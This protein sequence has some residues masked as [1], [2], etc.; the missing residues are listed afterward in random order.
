MP[1]C[2]GKNK[3]GTPC[4]RVLKNEGYCKSHRPADGSGSSAPN[5]ARSAAAGK[6]PTPPIPSKSLVT[7]A[8]PGGL[9]GRP[10]LVPAPPSRCGPVLPAARGL[11]PILSA[12]IGLA[13]V[14]STPPSVPVSFVVD[15]ETFVYP[16]DLDNLATALSHC[17][18]QLITHPVELKHMFAKLEFPEIVPTAVP[19]TWDTVVIPN[20]VVV[21]KSELPV[22]LG[23]GFP[24]EVLRNSAV[25][26]RGTTLRTLT[27]LYASCSGGPGS[28]F[29]LRID[30]DEGERMEITVVNSD[31]E[32]NPEAN[33][34]AETLAGEELIDDTEV[35]NGISDSEDSEDLP[36][37]DDY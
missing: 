20:N 13:S 37:E 23:G 17:S 33:P 28:F 18:Q 25:S 4:K 35:G 22:E 27:S 12:G 2:A 31:P 11:V 14:G 24:A 26:S 19:M 32:A 34:E 1:T 5:S 6:I 16:F 30:K 10:P 36:P 9:S 15:R 7:P 3:N 8:P 29:G 21:V